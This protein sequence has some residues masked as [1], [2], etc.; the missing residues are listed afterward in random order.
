MVAKTFGGT[1]YGV[2]ASIITVEVNIV[3]GTNFFLV[4]LP[5]NAIKES[6]Q[7]I[8]STL[9]HLEYKMPRQKVV[10]N[11]APADV[12]KEGSAYDLPIALSIL[13]L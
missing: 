5:D 9:K 8:E 11:L 3:Q 2:D 10:V 12:R 7:R 6:Q 4:G 1:T 13:H